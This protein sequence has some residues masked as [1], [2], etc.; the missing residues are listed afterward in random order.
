MP[1]GTYTCT[2]S[3]INGCQQTTN[4]TI[5][6]PSAL[7]SSITSLI[8]VSCFGGTN[9]SAEVG[10]T[11]PYLYAWSP[12]GGTSSLATNLSVGTCTCQV[13]DANGCL[14]NQAVQINTPSAITVGTS[15][16]S[17]ATCGS[18]NGALSL[19]TSG[20]TGSYTYSWTPSVGSTANL[21]NL[22]SGTYSVVVSD[23]NGCTGSLSVGI[24]TISGPSVA[25]ISKHL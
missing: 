22:F 10:G 25:L 8:P 9:G 11:T 13:T 1:A 7:S 12:S 19:V 21:I 20:G 18:N 15:S 23:Q 24:N 16:I 14:V 6:Q 3:D 2:I 17:P 5:L 4:V